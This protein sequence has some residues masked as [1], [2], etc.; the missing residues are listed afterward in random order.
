[1]NAD[2][3]LNI[4]D[5]KIKTI[6]VE[7]WK[8]DVNIKELGLLPMLDMYQS[9]NVKD[10]ESGKIEV[11]AIDIAKIV[12]MGVVDD[13]GCQVFTDEHIPALANK[14]RDALLFVYSEIMALSGT[15]VDA[16]KN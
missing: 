7:K 2:D 16:E 3:I 4:S 10:V 1:M 5:L 8:R 12:V 14:N 15:E 9:I 13:N 6:H 11:S